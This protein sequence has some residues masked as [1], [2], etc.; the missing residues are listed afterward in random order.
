MSCN[1]GFL[2]SPVHYTTNRKDIFKNTPIFLF[3]NKKDLFEDM[4][5]KQKID[6][7]VAF[8]E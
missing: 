6:L 3:L 5:T 7:N 1:L 8:P 2:P 4:V